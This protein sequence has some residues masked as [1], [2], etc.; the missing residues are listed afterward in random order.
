MRM[1]QNARNEETNKPMLKRA[2]PEDPGDEPIAAGD[3]IARARELAPLI[4]AHAAETEAGRC[5]APDVLSALHEA[6]LFRLLM[7]RSCDGLELDPEVHLRDGDG[8]GRFSLS[9]LIQHQDGGAR[10]DE[11]RQ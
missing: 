2:F 3:C 4:E 9:L 1:R 6:R 10:P 8:E 7:P 11:V 5:L